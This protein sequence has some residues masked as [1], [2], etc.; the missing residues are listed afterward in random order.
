MEF[1]LHSGTVV[2]IEVVKHVTRHFH[3]FFFFQEFPLHQL[4]D[5][6][7][8][9]S[10]IFGDELTG[11]VNALEANHAWNHFIAN[12]VFDDL[13]CKVLSANPVEPHFD[14]NS[15][16][17]IVNILFSLLAKLQLLLKLSFVL[18][19]VDVEVF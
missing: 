15:Y 4:L 5:A 19:F 1:K 9:L 12:Q 6:S 3:V 16:Y 18:F 13:L 10:V 17:K 8:T 7:S 14:R 2:H 11:L